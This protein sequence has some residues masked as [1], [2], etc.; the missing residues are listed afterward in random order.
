MCVHRAVKAFR[1]FT[2]LT[3][4]VARLHR[5]FENARVMRDA[6]FVAAQKARTA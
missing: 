5:A 4:D 1:Q 6:A 3:P 2:G